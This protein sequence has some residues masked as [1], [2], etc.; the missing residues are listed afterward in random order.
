MSSRLRT[1]PLDSA[2]PQP[3]RNGGG[4]TRELFA[5]PRAAR[6]LWRISVA[7][8]SQDGPFSAFPDVDRWF[9][10]LEGGGVM[11]SFLEGDRPVSMG[12]ERAYFDGVA[13]PPC[14]LLDGPTRD[15]N[16]M[17]RRDAGRSDMLRALPGQ[18]WV[19]RA[20]LRALFTAQAATLTIDGGRP[21]KLAP[22]TL[23]VNTQ[24]AQQAWQISVDSLALRPAPRT[25]WLY[26][27]P[28]P[29]M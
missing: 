3:W 18:P 6:W 29:F 8:I 10:V 4:V 1:I 9:A 2:A 17:M 26:F 21:R 22:W 27:Q 28:P 11:L 25:W 16:L 7:D 5:W 13:A 24:A 15:L 23:A 12:S 20:P 19:S 14:K